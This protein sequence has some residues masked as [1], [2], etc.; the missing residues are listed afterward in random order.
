M[1]GD[2]AY[3][4]VCG[5]LRDSQELVVPETNR[6]RLGDFVDSRMAEKGWPVEE[7][8]AFL[9]ADR[10]ERELLID[11]ATIGETYFFRDEAHFDLVRNRFLPFFAG[12]GRV[13]LVWSAAT[14]TGEEILSLA[15]LYAD[16]YGSPEAAAD[17]VWASDINALSLARLRE[18][19]FRAGSLRDDGRRHHGCL[20]PWLS[21]D[22]AWLYVDRRLVDLVQTRTVNLMTD[23]LD[24]IPGGIDLLFL[25]NMMIYFPHEKRRVIYR[26]VAAKLSDQG[27]LVLGKSEVPFFEHP[28]LTLVEEAGNFF[29]ARRGSPYRART[30]RMA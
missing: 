11:A 20:A 19:R 30:E 2:S 16:F 14:S 4:A 13:P 24:A 18:G 28:D 25:K 7:Y 3:Q 26:K 23:S 5:W 21:R 17:R 22:A 8:L 9:A 27:F 6:T 29:F 15:A 12:Q 1:I 10:H